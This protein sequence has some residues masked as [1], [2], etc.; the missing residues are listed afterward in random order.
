MSGAKVGILGAGSWGIAMANLLAA[1]S[2]EVKMW[3]F[4]PKACESLLQNREL[5]SKLPG[6]KIDKSILITNNLKEAS[7]SAEYIFSAVPAQF[8]RSALEGAIFGTVDK[9]AIFINLAKG[10]EVGS[11]KRMSEVIEEKIPQDS[12][13]GICTLSG[14]SHAEEVARNIPTA[15]TIASDSMET[16]KKV[17]GLFQSPNFRVY[18]SNDLVGVELAGSLKNV[19]ALAAGMLDGLELGDNT[20][21]ALIT[22]GLAEMVRLGFKMGA[23]PQTFSGLS[24]IGD[25]VTTCLSKHSRNR[26]VGEHIGR[27][28]KLNDVLSKMAMVAEGVETTRSAREL[29]HNNDVEMPITFEVYKVLFENKPPGIA[30]GDLMGR[31]QKRE[32]WE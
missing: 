13:S 23:D 6:I 14:P 27:G 4:D 10:I 16:A 21:G 26:Y 30:I 25:L 2:C 7:N 29:A 12:R 20:R 31:D 22:R 17:Q 19:I 11:L 8:L 15:V 28:E 32:F 18:S 24:G 1:N 9:G 3:E 5:P